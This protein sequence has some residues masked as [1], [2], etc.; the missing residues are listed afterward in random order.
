MIKKVS[1]WKTNDINLIADQSH[2]SSLAGAE[3]F[4]VCDLPLLVAIKR[5][6][7]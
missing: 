3:P 6:V 4:A 5:H 7:V 1:L 2:L